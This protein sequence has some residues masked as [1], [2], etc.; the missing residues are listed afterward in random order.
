MQIDYSKLKGPNQT[1]FHTIYGM[2][3]RYKSKKM[4]VSLEKKYNY[5]CHAMNLQLYT[6][7]GCKVENISRAIK[8]SQSPFASP[9]VKLMSK[10]RMEAFM[11]K[12]KLRQATYKL[13]NNR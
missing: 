10:Y 8:F 4:V 13:L 12:S 7:L 3:E 5:T 9:F 1:L 11:Q 6:Q 2:K